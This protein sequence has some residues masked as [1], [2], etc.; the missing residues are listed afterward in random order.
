MRVG[1]IGFI[2][3]ARLP[4]CDLLLSSPTY[5]DVVELLAAEHLALLPDVEGALWDSLKHGTEAWNAIS[6]DGHIALERVVIT[7]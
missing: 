2:G 1:C 6:G 4:H 3:G 7:L 5:L